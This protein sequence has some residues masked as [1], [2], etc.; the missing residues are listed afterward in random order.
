MNIYICVY[1]GSAY[2]V[3]IYVVYIYQLKMYI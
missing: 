1:M 2:D 3:Y